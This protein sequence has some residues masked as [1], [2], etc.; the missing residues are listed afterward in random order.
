[1]R[2]FQALFYYGSEVDRWLPEV[3]MLPYVSIQWKQDP[4]WYRII[5]PPGSGK[6][7]HLSLLEGYE[8][9]YVID[10]FT[11][12]S[13]VSGFRGPEGDDPSK[14]PMF[15]GKVLIIGDES[16]LMEQRQEDRNTVQSI[17]RKAYDGRYTK[18][19]GNIKEKCEYN[20]HFNLLVG[21]TPQIDRYFI[22]NQ[23]LGERYI[24]FRLQ[25]PDRRAL[26]VRAYKNQFNDFHER[27]ANLKKMVHKYLRLL[28]DMEITEVSI[29]EDMENLFIDTAN[30]ISLV[31]THITRDTTG[32]HVTTLPQAEAA[33]RL[34]QQMTKTAIS[35]AILNGDKVV[36]IKHAIKAIY[37][38]IGSIM[39]VIS[40]ILFHILEFTDEVSPCSEASW[41]TIQYMC[42]KTALSRGSIA[43][44]LEDLAIH[45]VLNIRQG[46]KQGG[47]LFEYSLSSGAYDMI[48]TTKLFEYYTPPCR[49]ILS[50][51]RLDRNRPVGN[52]KRRKLRKRRTKAPSA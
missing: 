8:L 3:M 4:T 14:L 44:I 13:F 38:G 43:R 9:S 50:L 11:P 41:F 5:A 36:N 48:K 42:V 23:A 30:F 34:V 35:D 17:L 51:K 47:R 37:F 2:E 27:Y 25:I 45:R 49:E 29:N 40:F 20:S 18:S 22:Y 24:N 15:D 39:A 12:K 28:P 21:S 6:S 7:K 46:K 32:R 31:R 26:T 1:M 52:K 33:G 19:F 10:E 16:T